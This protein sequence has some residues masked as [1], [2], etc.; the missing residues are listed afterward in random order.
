M[1]TI[2]EKWLEI[3]KHGQRFISDFLEDNNSF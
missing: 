1:K 2:L 3:N